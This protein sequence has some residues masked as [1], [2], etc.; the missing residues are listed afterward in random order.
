LAYQIGV[1]QRTV[2]DTERGRISGA[3]VGTIERY[4]SVLGL[5]YDTLLAA[6]SEDQEPRRAR[7]Y[8]SKVSRAE[9]TERRRRVVQLVNQIEWRSDRFEFIE[10]ILE[11][12]VAEDIDPKGQQ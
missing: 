10:P 5:D 11:R 6:V 8:H 7:I 3:R 2:S 4:A 9:N 1:S 12:M